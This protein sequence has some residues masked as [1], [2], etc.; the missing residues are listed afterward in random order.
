M[1]VADL[2]IIGRSVHYSTQTSP[3]IS[4]NN[5]IVPN[6]AQEIDHKYT[7]TTKDA[8]S[9]LHLD[10]S[11]NAT[12]TSHSHSTKSEHRSPTSDS[13][14]S[15]SESPNSTNSGESPR[16]TT[17]QNLTPRRK[18]RTIGNYCVEKTIGRGQFGKVKLAYHKK[19]PD[20]KVAIKIIN[21]TKLDED[22]LRMIQREVRIMKLLN[23]PHIIRLYE[24]IETT[25]MLFLIMEYAEGGE[26]MDYIIAH[27]K[28]PEREAKRFFVQILSALKYCHSKRCCHRDLKP[29]NLLL[30]SEVNIKIIDFGLSNVFTPGS[31][32]KT[33][34]GSPTY[35]SP[36][37]I[38]RKEYFGP[39]V[40][41]WSMG[42]VLYVLVCGYLPF[43]G[44]NFAELFNKILQAQYTIPSHVSPEC[45]A[46]I[47][48][49][50]VV[51]PRKR[52]TLDEIH[53]H[54]WLNSVSQYVPALPNSAEVDDEAKIDKEI[55]A[56]MEGFGFIP[57]DVV[58]SLLNNNYNDAAAMY[59]LLE[60]KKQKQQAKRVS[61]EIKGEKRPAEKMDAATSPLAPP[62]PEVAKPQN[63]KR[64]HRRIHTVDACT[65]SPPPPIIP[66]S[67]TPVLTSVA[68]PPVPVV[69]PLSLL[70]QAVTP[71]AVSPPATITVRP[72]DPEK[73][74]E[75]AKTEKE[76][77]KGSGVRS[78][79]LKGRGHH[80]RAASEAM[81]EDMLQQAKATHELLK[82]GVATP[83]KLPHDRKRLPPIKEGEIETDM[84]DGRRP[85]DNDAG[86]SANKSPEENLVL[87]DA[88]VDDISKSQPSK[89]G[90]SSLISSFKSMLKKVDSANP[91][92]EEGPQP[93]VVR[94]AFSLNTTSERPAVDIIHEVQRVLQEYHIPYVMKG[95]F[96]ADC[97]V[98]N[99]RF[100]IEVCRL[101]RLSVSGVRLS[102][103]SGSA[104]KYKT[105]AKDLV[106]NM[107]L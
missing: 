59:F 26:V 104:W 66:A 49:M 80:R 39:A 52:A 19:I 92:P 25:R 73:D 45:A 61:T 41:V 43:D 65:S 27:G 83:Q 56:T 68:A 107:K 75:E 24:V 5:I 72:K 29:E 38:L 28:I 18:V 81:K 106:T 15:S 11:D 62:Q 74:L 32:L 13:S 69:P 8:P 89:S 78:L 50:L 93:R 22:T 4:Q 54:G 14:H 87:T 57:E 77:G 67:R 31:L 85:T 23:H 37:L 82:Q 76:K 6:G 9:P 51:D 3:I 33:F 94:F 101:P 36:E 12:I 42:V 16:V 86:A 96:C 53:H 97:V 40:D 20:L 70:S 47:E 35:A 84:V 64:G 71:P 10:L 98:D 58:Q 17:T 105:I 34:C 99:V 79:R 88:D 7:M 100:S 30:D 95:M 103:I 2:S 21:K 91:K 102:R 48:R 1:D 63:F 90:M 44:H 55:I 46:L 60:S